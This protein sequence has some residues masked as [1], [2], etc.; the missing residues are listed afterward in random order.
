MGSEERERKEEMIEEIQ[1]EQGNRVI[2]WQNELAHNTNSAL[3]YLLHLHAHIL[4]SFGSMGQE[5]FLGVY[6]GDLV[7]VQVGSSASTCRHSSKYEEVC[8]LC[9]CVCVCVCMRVVCVSV[10]SYEVNKEGKKRNCRVHFLR[11]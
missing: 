7:L 8:V 10:H 9:V 4:K 11:Y 3:F 6:Q 5:Q 1:E 2:K